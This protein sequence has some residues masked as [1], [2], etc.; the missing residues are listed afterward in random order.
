MKPHYVLYKGR[1]ERVGYIN[2]I[3]VVLVQVEPDPQPDGSKYCNQCKFVAAGCARI[4]D[5]REVL[6]LDCVSAANLVYKEVS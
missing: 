2:G 5:S 4:D 6:G 3:K 1:P